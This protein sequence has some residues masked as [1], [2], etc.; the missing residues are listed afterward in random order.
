MEK[1]AYPVRQFAGATKRVVQTLDLKDDPELVAAYK[2]W[3]SRE[4]I[5][6]EILQGIKDS[7]VLEMEI[8]LLGTRL[9]MIVELAASDS[10]DEVMARMGAGPRQAEWEAFVARFQ[11]A[12]PPPGVQKNGS[13]WSVFSMCMNSGQALCRSYFGTADVTKSK[14]R[15]PHDLCGARR[16]FYWCGGANRVNGLLNC[17]V[18]GTKAR[19]KR[20]R[21]LYFSSRS[22]RSRFVRSSDCAISHSWIFAS[23]PER[24]TSGT[25]QPL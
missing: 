8:Y 14:R 15:A 2:H 21:S 22:G 9:F 16:F 17:A 18:C 1:Y 11:R 3:H 23:C 5:W 19:C 12:D 4:G 6:P 10:W 20:G 7:G 25:F 13:A 24:S